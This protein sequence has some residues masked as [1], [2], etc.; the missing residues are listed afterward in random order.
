MPMN[1][2]LFFLTLGLV[3]VGT[4]VGSITYRHADREAQRAMELSRTHVLQS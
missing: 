3:I 2:I 1:R 4:A